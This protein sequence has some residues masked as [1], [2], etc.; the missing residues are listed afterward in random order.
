M[1]VVIIVL[2]THDRQLTLDEISFIQAQSLTNPDRRSLLAKS[3]LSLIQV[4]CVENLMQDRPTQTA[5]LDCHTTGSDDAL[6]PEI[7]MLLGKKLQVTSL[8]R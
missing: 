8:S 6:A 7:R 1:P 3:Q 4:E 2:S 5:I